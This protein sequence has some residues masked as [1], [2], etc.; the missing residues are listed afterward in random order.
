MSKIEVNTVDV[1][2]GSTLTLGS[3]G[4]TVTLA[5]GASQTGFGRTGTVSWC[6]TVKTSPL[7]A[8]SGKGYFVNTCGGVVTVTLPTSP[9]AGDIVSINDFK[10]T[11][12]T[13]KV[14]V[15]RGGSKIGGTAACATLSSNGQSVTF[16]YSGSCQGWTNIQNQTSAVVGFD[17][18]NIQYLV[19]AGGASGGTGDIAGGGGAGGYRFVPGKSFSVLQGTPI[20]VTVGG[21]GAQRCRSGTCQGNPGSNSVFS[22]I[23]SAGGGGGGAG[24]GYPQPTSAGLAGGSGGGAGYRCATGGAGNTPSVPVS[25]GNAGGA[26]GGTP[27]WFMGGGGGHAAA[28]TD[29]APTSGGCGGAGTPS[30]LDLGPLGPSY[31]TPGPAPGRYFA[32]GGGG[33][34]DTAGCAGA[35]GAGGGGKGSSNNT[36]SVAGTTNTGGG[37]G[38]GEGSNPTGHGAAGGSGFVAIR[39]V[40]ACASGLVSGG[41]AT[42]TCGADTIRLFTGDGTFIP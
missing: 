13:N 26:S 25:Q 28:G 41:D 12:A 34:R 7:T 27:D 22:T 17:N 5:C 16:V 33:G 24:A 15:G 14:T 30:A 11:F 20:T 31:G 18:Y 39:Y 36:P 19:V 37:G 29:G 8:T 10:R 38:G 1:Q 42:T 40:T 9:S 35:G 2:C 23:T 21:G 6:T 4:K 32:G 3:S